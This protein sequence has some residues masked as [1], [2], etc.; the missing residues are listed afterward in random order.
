MTSVT[1]NK[2][3]IK[4]GS[5]T[6]NQK[7]GRAPCDHHCGGV[8][9]FRRRRLI[10]RPWEPLSEIKPASRR[11]GR[12]VH[13]H[14]RLSEISWRHADLLRNCSAEELFQWR[15]VESHQGWG[16]ADV[17]AATTHPDSV[18]ETW[19]RSE[20]RW[21]FWHR[22]DRFQP[23]AS[24][25]SVHE[26]TDRTLWLRHGEPVPLWVQETEGVWHSDSWD[27]WEDLQVLFVCTASDSWPVAHPKVSGVALS[28][29]PF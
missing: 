6:K 28:V 24:G 16:L 26:P 18:W 13:F 21:N 9:P 14:S 7:Q 23:D 20:W 3:I 8:V 22:E 25:A 17:R 15:W 27:L 2:K 29:F 5:I 4:N 19:S 1:N 12:K 11:S 10:Q